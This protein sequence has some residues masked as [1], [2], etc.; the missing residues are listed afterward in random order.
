MIAVIAVV[1]A[2]AVWSIAHRSSH[3]PCEP[4]DCKDCPFPL[5]LDEERKKNT[6]QQ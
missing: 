5:C 4:G 3:A 2:L 1:V 6:G